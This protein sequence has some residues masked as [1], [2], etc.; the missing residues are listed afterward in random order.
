MTKQKEHEGMTDQMFVEVGCRGGSWWG[1]QPRY[2]LQKYVA[3]EL[4][5]KAQEKLTA[6]HQPISDVFILPFAYGF[7]MFCI[8]KQCTSKFW[9]LFDHQFPMRRYVHM[10]SCIYIN[11]YKCSVYSTALSRVFRPFLSNPHIEYVYRPVAKH[12]HIV[13]LPLLRHDAPLA[14]LRPCLSWQVRY[15]R[16]AACDVDEKNISIWQKV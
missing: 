12:S 16:S 7:A 9:C 8:W 1:P 2:G 4:I 13:K 15:T 6:R 3:G 10:F 5:S 14:G 11:S